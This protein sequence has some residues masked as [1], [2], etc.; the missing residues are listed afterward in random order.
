MFLTSGIL[1]EC[2]CRSNP[3]GAELVYWADTVFGDGWIVP[4]FRSTRFGIVCTTRLR[5][6]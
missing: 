5:F 6:A 1:H 2:A 4:R 3:G